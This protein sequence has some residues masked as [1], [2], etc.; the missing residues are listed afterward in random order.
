MKLSE[1]KDFLK[2][3]GKSIVDLYLPGCIPCKQMKEIVF[4]EIKNIP[5][6]YID[7]SDDVEIFEFFVDSSGQDI[8]GV[9]CILLYENG[10]FIKRNDG[11][12]NLNGLQSFIEAT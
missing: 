1:V 5:I 9:P 8:S 7:C 3:P 6:L 11:F 10:N 2:K 12:L 4:P